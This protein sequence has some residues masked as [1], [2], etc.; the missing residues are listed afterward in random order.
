[1]ASLE[2]IRS[3][4]LKKIEALKNAGDNSYPI[5]SHYTH[6]LKSVKD[7]FTDLAE[8]QT[9]VTLVGRVMARR[10]QG[11]LIFFD[12]FDGTGRFQA[13]AKKDV[14]GEDR[15]AVFDATVDVGDF[16]QVSGTL[17]LT[18]QGEKTLQ[19]DNWSMLAKSLRPL[20]DKWHGLQDTEERFRKRY[21]DS[22]M[23]DGVRERFLLR[24]KIIGALRQF[25]NEQDFVEMETSMLQ[26]LAGGATAEPF[27][28]HHEAL[29]IDLF[30]RLAPEL[31]LKKMLVGG[32]PRVYEIGR[33]FRNEGIDTTHNPE[34][35]MLE[36]YES[37]SD[38]E[39]G[40]ERVEALFKY[41][42]QTVFGELSVSFDDQVI[43]FSKPFMVRKYLDLIAEYTGLTDVWSL[44]EGELTAFAEKNS[45]KIDPAYDKAKI[46]DH[47]YKK[48]CRPQVI[49]PTFLVDYPAPFSPLAKKKEDNPDFIDRFQL[50]IGGMEM[51]N[52]FSELNDPLDQR[53]RFMEQEKNKERG[54]AE[55]Q[56]KDE[57]YLEAMEYGLPPAFGFGIGL[58]RLV[59]LLTDTKSIKEVIYFP[60]LRPKGE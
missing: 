31:D 16:V 46:I 51:V 42:L 57:E 34:F 2:E 53:A 8:A 41:I 6:T 37:F 43:D 19:A 12:L 56:P 59:M 30:L 15:L 52:A 5:K 24:S 25:L 21:L 14:L 40:R 39:K 3:E 22:L 20:P 1:M 50:L 28:T 32:F 47:I 7:G 45:I 60:T 44:S 26:A 9:K 36:A 54:D 13:V 58:D 33:C 4:R 17:F 10:G 48:M 55:A 38:A 35:T 23:E 11:A 18:K 27:K 29:D 49:Q